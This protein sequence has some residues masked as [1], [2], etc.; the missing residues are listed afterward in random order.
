VMGPTFDALGARFMVIGPSRLASTLRS[1]LADLTVDAPGEHAL[2]VEHT[3]LRRWSVWWDDVSIAV[4]VDASMAL[5]SALR[6]VNARAAERASED[7]LVL[8]GACVEIDGR[9]VAFV[10]D[11]GAGKTTLAVA[12]LKRGHPL[13]CEE[14]TAVAAD[15]SVAA[16][17]RPLGIRSETAERLALPR[18]RG[19][20][21]YVHPVEASSL[22]R[23]AAG[24]TL[25][26]VVL[27]VW[28]DR[29]AEPVHLEPADALIRL[30]NHTLGAVGR[31]RAAFR[32]AA[33]LVSAVPVFELAVAEV[34]TAL[35]RI[36]LLAS[37]K[38]GDASRGGASIKTI[39]TLRRTHGSS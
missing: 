15:L 30:M 2:R 3:G 28:S 36:R 34:S 1:S 31:E 20:F 10:G 7:R 37:T 39:P 14:A 6:A 18:L 19:P 12:A 5:Y 21:R 17:H 16:F 23:L 25:G 22:G 8:H 35:D 33:H 32:A 27:P 9:G 13:V 24:A 38:G 4:A 29:P 11:S 26:L